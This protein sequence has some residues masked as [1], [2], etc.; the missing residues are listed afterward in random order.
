[1]GVSLFECHEKV[2]W[3]QQHYD[4]LWPEIDT[5][6]KRDDHRIVVE[7]NADEGEYVFRVFDLPTPH[8]DWGL[9]IGD[10]LHNARAALD[11]LMVRL[12]ALGTGIEPGDVESVQFPVCDSPG[13]FASSRTV[14]DFRACPALSVYLARIKELHNP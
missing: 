8:R 2:R 11:Y 6:Q 5:F 9:R 3:A 4:S 1:V 14:Q 12:Y 13:A 7:V 10:C